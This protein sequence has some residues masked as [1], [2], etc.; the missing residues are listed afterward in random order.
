MPIPSLD[1]TVAELVYERPSYFLEFFVP[2]L[3]W[4]VL[5]LLNFWIWSK[6]KAQGNLLMLVGAGI[7]ALAKLIAAID[8]PEGKFMM[9]WLPTIGVA[10]FA[11]GFYRTVAV[12]VSAQLAALKQKAADLAKPDSSGGDNAS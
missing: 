8:F 6:S 7:A 1:F 11:F 12:Q 2:F 10:V 9:F 4:G 5:A 3:I